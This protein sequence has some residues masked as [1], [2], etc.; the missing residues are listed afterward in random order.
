MKVCFICGYW[1]RLTD[2]I[3]G[4]RPPD[5]RSAYRYVWGVKHGSFK[6]PFSLIFADGSREHVNP[7]N[8]EQV[9]KRFGRFIRLRLV[10]NG[11]EDA[12]L[13]HVPSKCAVLDEE[14]PRSLLMLREAIAESSL[15]DALCDA[16]RW[17]E[18]LGA[19][20]EGGERRKKE[21]VPFLRVVEDVSGRN[22]V[23]VDD[24]LTRGG[25]ILAC[26]E[27]LEK[28]G[29]NVVGAITCGMTMYSRDVKA[30]GNQAF[31]LTQELDDYGRLVQQ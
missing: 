16:I 5:Y 30:F 9:R 13:V 18:P 8:F 14:A 21:L 11:W 25:T 22:V 29:A 6:V 26:K 12:L 19:A 3:L 17:T 27:V 7:R 24:L 1:S 10:E 31:E 15:A 4:R 2:Q 20:H 23:L 28:A